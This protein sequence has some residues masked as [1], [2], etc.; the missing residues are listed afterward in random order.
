MNNWKE[1]REKKAFIALEDGTIFR[2]WS[3]GAPVNVL[4]EVVFNTGLCGYQEIL[5]DPS[6]SGQIVTMT[7]PEIGNYGIN[8]DDVEQKKVYVN[9]FLVHSI[10]EPSNWR[11]VE[12]VA[13]YLKRYN[14][15][16]VAGIDT[17]ALTAQL[18][19]K[20][21]LKAFI[22]TQG[23]VAPEDAVE[24]AKSWVGL[25]GQD[26][27]KLVS[28]ADVYEWDPTGEL[29]S[30]WGATETLLPKTDLNVV[31]YDFGI[32]WN[33]LRRMRQ[34]GMRVT[35]V[36]ATTPAK[37]VLAMKPD[38]VF[39]SNGPADPAAVTYAAEAIRELI[40]KVPLF[41]ICLGHQ[42]LGLAAGGRTKRLKFGHH[43]C[44]HPVKDLLTGKVEITSQN[45]NFTVEM[46]T[47]DPNEVE[48][49]H[50]NLND[51]TVEGLQLKN[52]KAFSVQYHPEAAP[53]PHD[54]GYLFARFRELM[55]K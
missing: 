2:G 34:Q 13:Q 10:N 38:G 50:V 3:F 4:G 39:L 18:R 47:L 23:D 21:T 43:G 25:D 8:P 26:Y 5:T 31:A 36:P 30:S 35:V 24:K 15:P 27:V 29:S 51:M 48:V 46:D 40:G 53:G 7:C 33:I 28:T 44:N 20:G 55:G 12:S 6:Y 49:T 11:S 45:H 54:S 52:A 19:D 41:G 14:V 9:G 17:R 22:C 16:G 37:D 1:Q 32:K 42:L